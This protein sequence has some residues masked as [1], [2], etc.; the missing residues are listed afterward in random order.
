MGK[1]Q[2]LCNAFQQSQFLAE[3]LPNDVLRESASLNILHAIERAAVRQRAR[4][5]HGNDPR[6]F[7]TRQDTR[8]LEEA[9]SEI[10]C[11]RYEIQHLERDS[12]MPPRIVR[13]PHTAHASTSKVAHDAVTCSGEVGL[14]YL[15]LQFGD[16]TIRKLPHPMSTPSS[17]RAS[18]RYSSSEV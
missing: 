3:T 1:I 5:V 13:Q 8:F 6:M 18:R 12:A 16:D 11:R 4:V 17:I 9:C 15:S 10:V 14:S 2:R 7:E